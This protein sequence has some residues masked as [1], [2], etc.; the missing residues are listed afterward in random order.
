MSALQSLPVQREMAALLS[1]YGADNL[2]ERTFA[3]VSLLRRIL[4]QIASC[5]STAECIGISARLEV[6]CKDIVEANSY[7]AERYRDDVKAHVQEQ[8]ANTQ[9]LREENSRLQQQLDDSLARQRIQD[10]QRQ[11]TRF[12]VADLMNFLG[13]HATSACNRDLLAHFRDCT[14]VPSTWQTVIATTAGDDPLSQPGPFVSMDRPDD[15]SDD[16]A[17]RDGNPGS[18]SAPLPE[19]APPQQR[20]RRPSSS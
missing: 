4:D 9:R 10:Q 1:E 17:Q 20:S 16:V 8:D 13:D 2:A 5:L 12:E 11:E 6:E 18:A 15:N 19:V 3:T 14:P 7:T